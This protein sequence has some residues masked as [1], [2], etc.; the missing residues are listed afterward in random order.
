MLF[1]FLR[2]YDGK[3][4]YSLVII[5]TFSHDASSIWWRCFSKKIKKH[6]EKK[7]LRKGILDEAFRESKFFF[8]FTHSY[9]AVAAIVLETSTAFFCCCFSWYNTSCLYERLC[10]S[11]TKRSTK[12]S[13]YSLCN[14]QGWLEQ[15]PCRRYI[16]PLLQDTALASSST[17][18]SLVWNILNFYQFHWYRS[19]IYQLWL[20]FQTSAFHSHHP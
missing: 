20:S 5:L 6:N 15:I 17:C 16:F 19:L 1:P 18:A 2:F 14:S 3:C 13:F 7:I 12:E 9:H 4:Y 11:T 10:Q 8:R